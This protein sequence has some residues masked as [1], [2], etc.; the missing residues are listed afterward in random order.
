MRLWSLHPQYLD[1][2]GLL[3]CWREGL[4]A[5]KVLQ[6]ETKGYTHHPQLIRFR[7]QGK[8]LG[9]IGTYLTALADEADR[10]GY[11]FDRSKINP[12]RFAGQIPV[13]DGQILYEWEHLK[14]K[15]QARDAE[16]Y[17]E[18]Q[19]VLFPTAHPLF[20]VVEGP[21]EPWEKINMIS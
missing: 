12:A 17:R 5:Q 2:Q 3:A 6:G 1:R 14:K 13:T 18:A 11:R 15:L 9:A 10:R 21:L 7:T 16:R 19:V 4:L 8:P 20:R